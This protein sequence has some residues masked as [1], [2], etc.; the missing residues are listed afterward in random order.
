MIGILITIEGFLW[1]VCTLAWI[2]LDPNELPESDRIARHNAHWRLTVWPFVFVFAAASALLVWTW[3]SQFQQLT[4]HDKLILGI[5]SLLHVFLGGMVLSV[6]RTKNQLLQEV[7]AEWA[8]VKPNE[9]AEQT[10]RGD[11][12][13]RA[14]PQK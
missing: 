4:T 3:F 13:N 10:S 8:S 11:V 6:R 7:K 2:G 14:A 9:K 5:E 1:F 12:A